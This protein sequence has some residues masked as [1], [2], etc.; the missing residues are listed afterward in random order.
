MENLIR[1]LL[2]GVVARMCGGGFGAQYLDFVLFKTPEIQFKIFGKEI[3]LPSTEFKPTMLPEIVFGAIFGY[4]AFLITGS[5]IYALLTTVWSYLWME[6]GHG[7]V[8]GWGNRLETAT[9]AEKK[10]TQFLSPVVDWLAD[11]LS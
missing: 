8:L 9:D 5:L 7:I 1:V 10:R 11:R 6:T 3:Y 2:V 4:A